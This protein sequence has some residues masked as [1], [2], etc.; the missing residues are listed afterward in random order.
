MPSSPSRNRGF[1]AAHP[2]A[3]PVVPQLTVPWALAEA[4]AFHLRGV[5]WLARADRAAAKQCAEQDAPAYLAAERAR[6]HAVRE[7]MGSEAELW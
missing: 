6:L 4:Q 3:I 2:P 1:P 7:R 5:G